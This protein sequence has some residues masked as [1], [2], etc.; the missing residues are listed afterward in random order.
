M[1]GRLPLADRR[2]LLLTRAAIERVQMRHALDEFR[3]ARRPLALAAEVL[4]RPRG[5]GMA[6]A[7]V[8]G[9]LARGLAL[10]REHPY[11][12]SALSLALGAARGGARGRWLRRLVLTAALGVAGIWAMSA[13]RGGPGEKARAEGPADEDA[14]AEGP[15]PQGPLAGG[16]S[17]EGSS[18]A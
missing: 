11:L 10:F 6:G 12:G 3:R 13:V 4:L 18:G 1:S 5:A 16:S 8:A 9:V 14:A 17:G 2:Q 7:G 15:H